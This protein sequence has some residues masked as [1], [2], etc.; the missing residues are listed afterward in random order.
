M[1][2]KSLRIKAV[3]RFIDLVENMVFE[4]R[5]RKYYRI[6][7]QVQN[8]NT[9]IDVGA[10]KGQSI[11][12]FLSINPLVK[13]YA[14]EPNPRL[15]DLLVDKYSKWPRVKIFNL[16]VSDVSGK[17]MFFENVFDYTSSFEHLN[18]ESEYLKRKAR[19]LG[20][21]TDQIIAKK[22]P[23]NVITIDEL[24]KKE[25]F[26]ERIDIIKIDTEGHEY[27]CLKGLFENGLSKPVDL[28]QIENHNDD[29]YRDRIPYD[30]IRHLLIHNGFHEVAT[31]K[32]GFSNL[33]EVVYKYI[34]C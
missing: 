31:I 21:K 13:I 22:Y 4:R 3:K 27:Y 18:E 16:G 19:I 34:G 7:F 23:V 12:F 8:L 17:K 26:E 10:N 9:V 14:L 32:H 6:V 30:N 15:Y 1:K 25:V 5:M 24:I 20:V 2:S 29:M 28:I 33:D 11:D